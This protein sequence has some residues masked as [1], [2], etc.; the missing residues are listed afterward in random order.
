MNDVKLDYIDGFKN[1]FLNYAKNNIENIKAGNASK[2]GF[3]Q[4]V[5]TNV[6]EHSINSHL[7]KAERLSSQEILDYAKDF[8]KKHVKIE[9][10]DKSLSKKE[11]LAK[12]SQI[13]S[14]EDAFMSL[15][16]SKIG[17]KVNEL[18]VDFAGSNGV[19]KHGSISQLTKAM[20]NYFDDA[21]K[22]IHNALKKDASTN[23]DD[24]L[25]HLTKYKMGSRL[26]TNIGLFLAV[27]LFYTQIPKL[28]NMG[29][30]GD[31]SLGVDKEKQNDK[32]V[33]S[34][35]PAFTGGMTTALEKTGNWVFNKKSL[36]AISD[37]FELNGPVI[38]G[39]SMTALLYGFCIPPR[40]MNAQ[41]KY[42]YKTI[43]VRDLTAFS[44]LL[45]GAK[46]LAR[47]FSD[48]FT[49]LTGLALN[50]KNLK[51][52]NTFQ[53]VLDYLNPTGGRHSVLSSKQL[54]SKYTN[55]ENYK[56]GVE[57]LIE[58]I[59]QSGGNIK[60]ALSKDKNVMQVVE[61][62]L[63]KSYNSATAEEIKNVLK[64]GNKNKTE[65]IKK[66]YKLFEGKNG[67]L[68]KA[69][70]CNSAFDFLS[71]LVLVPGLIIWLTKFCKKMTERDK[72][73][74]EAAMSITQIQRAPLI[75]TS[76]PTMA[77]FLNRAS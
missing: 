20:G 49:K 16:K 48:G 2:E 43:F 14:I 36:K 61:K 51:G 44:A 23:I 24:L 70:T 27:A 63:G 28:Y 66:F 38:E 77:G 13:G 65:L 29:L 75:P 56:N 67:L 76:R 54:T 69:K 74:D 7:P 72:A 21:V 41:S 22:N 35:N 32:V 12:L 53:K 30:K 42:D 10:I 50:D 57:G 47:L 33:A 58:F 68:N 8:A 64:A 73:R 18:A 26:L 55:I 25:K 59:E 60:K 31:P 6:I 3:Y 52:R 71:T 17:G 9:N 1:S 5:Y 34:K 40:L 45:F 62:M 37:I 11:R 19:V 4:N 46:A 39:A 15:R